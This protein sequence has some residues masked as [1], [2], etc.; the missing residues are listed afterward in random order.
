MV[1]MEHIRQKLVSYTKLPI[2]FHSQLSD[3]AHLTHHRVR[4]LLL[5]HVREFHDVR[6]VCQE[7]TTQ[8]GVK[9]EYV[10]NL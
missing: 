9:E 5:V 1:T 6:T 10:A 8:K 3:L 7:G 2:Y 4:T